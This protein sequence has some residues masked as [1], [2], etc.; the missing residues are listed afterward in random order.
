VGQHNT[1][2]FYPDKSSI[3]GSQYGM[4]YDGKNNLLYVYSYR[5]GSSQMFLVNLTIP[6]GALVH[7]VR[8][9]PSMPYLSNLQFFIDPRPSPVWDPTG[10]RVVFY[11]QGTV[12]WVYSTN[13]TLIFRGPPLNNL[14]DGVGFYDAS[15]NWSL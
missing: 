8:I 1:S 6:S 14:N 3:C 15:F 4:Q 10:F 11:I 2:K 13:G 5:I 12:P 7:P 9:W